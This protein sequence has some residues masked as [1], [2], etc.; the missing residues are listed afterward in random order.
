MIPRCFFHSKQ[1]FCWL[2]FFHPSKYSSWWRRLK[3][4]LKTSF[5][6]VFKRRLQDVLMETDIFLLI[7]RLQDVLVKTNIFVLS[8]KRSCKNDFK[9]SSRR[10]Q[11]LF[12]TSCQ[13]FFKT[14]SR[15]LANTFW[16][17]LHD[18][19]KTSSKHPQDVFLRRLQDVFKTYHQVKL[20]L[21][22]N[23]W[24]VF[25]M[26]VRCTAKTIVYRR[27]HLGHTS[28]KFM[29]TVQNLQEW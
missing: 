21:L 28:E 19:L 24:E 15:R 29:V 27:I 3:D 25:N 9:T 26:F 22:T 17:H 5:V 13:Y 10:L 8:F 2:R 11:D 20:F 12:K 7:I 1:A 18:I 14:S 23:L 16:R 6:F 4:V